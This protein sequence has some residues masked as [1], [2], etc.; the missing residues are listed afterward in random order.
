MTN[1]PKTYEVKPRFLND[2]KKTPLEIIT[3]DKSQI[4]LLKK[5]FK[6]YYLVYYSK[7][8][9]I[10]SFTINYFKVDLNG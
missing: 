5:T 7:S 3:K 9:K 6:N 1:N 2:Y 10:Y 4:T 8:T